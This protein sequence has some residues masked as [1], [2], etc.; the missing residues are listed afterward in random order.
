[1]K[2]GSEGYLPKVQDMIRIPSSYN[3]YILWDVFRRFLT[4]KLSCIVLCK[5]DLSKNGKSDGS[6]DSHPVISRSVNIVLE[7]ASNV[8]RISIEKHVSFHTSNPG[9]RVDPANAG[10]KLGHCWVKADE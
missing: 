4:T 9:P 7:S 10:S 1:M 3:I 6:S 5:L 8:T 2:E